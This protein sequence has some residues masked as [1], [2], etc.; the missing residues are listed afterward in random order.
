MQACLTVKLKTDC[1]IAKL[2]SIAGRIYHNVY[3]QGKLPAIDANKDYSWNLATLLGFGDNTAFV[4][5]LRL[6]ITI[7]R[8]GHEAR[9]SSCF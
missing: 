2:P 9:S 3:G 7:H 1:R 6:Y 8:Y 4:D 5:L